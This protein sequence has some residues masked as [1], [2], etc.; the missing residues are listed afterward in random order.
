MKLSQDMRRGVLVAVVLGSVPTVV[1]A[2][3][4]AL[5]APKQE[6]GVEKRSV[7]FSLDAGASYNFKS[8]LD[9]DS[10]EVSVVRT[11]GQLNIAFPI[12]DRSRLVITPGFLYSGYDFEGANG[13]A[14]GF[15]EP[16]SDVWEYK[17]GATAYLVQNAKWSYIVGATI[18]SHGEQDATF[19]DTL[20]YSAIGGARYAFSDTFALTGGLVVGSRLEDSIGVLPLLAFEWL[21]DDHW[22]L[23]STRGRI[24]SD[25]GTG[26]ALG[27]RFSDSFELRL[28]GSYTSYN[29]RLDE[30]GFNPD[31]VVSDR[32]VPVALTAEWKFSPHFVLEL[33]GGAHVWQEYHV[34]DSDGNKLSTIETDTQ[35]FLS[36]VL[37]VKF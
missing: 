6:E 21:I 13:I 2:Q 31:G 26:L 1:L 5:E 11:G 7:D 16:W 23:N 32:R 12:R 30:D 8:D 22:S 24:Q 10:G 4:T 9:D 20:T 33:S 35:P 34:K 25:L 14:P 37:D 19:E 18:D 15:D 29:F 27:Y 17:L 36:L 3:E 28:S